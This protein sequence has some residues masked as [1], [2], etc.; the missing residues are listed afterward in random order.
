MNYKIIFVLILVFLLSNIVLA[1]NYDVT[2]HTVNVNINV[3]GTAEITEKFYLY[4]G[5][6]QDKIKFRQKSLEFGSSLE[7]WKEFNPV[8][9]PTI[10]PN[11]IING[12]ITYSESEENFL[13]IK[14]GLSDALMAKGKET[15]LMEEFNIKATYLNNLFESG[16]WIIPDNTIISIE[17]PAGAELVDNVSPDAT[18]NLIGNR[19]II[20][21]EGYK[22]AN[23][24]NVRY[25]LWKKINPLLDL[26]ELT[27]FLFRTNEGF[28]I[29]GFF[30]IIIGSII[31]K[32]KYFSSKI[33]SFVENNTLFEEDD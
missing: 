21:W 10:G 9:M 12:K 32:R 22:S 1:Q 30:I 14:Y 19:R 26:N 6:E 7:K 17:L 2:R 24:L 11:N 33:E 23:R 13:E 29:I 8:F 16:L 25:I 5:N 15:N 3:D 20:V 27:N 4:F 18:I 31:W 28:V